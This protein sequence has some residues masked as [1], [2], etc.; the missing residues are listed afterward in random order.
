MNFKTEEDVLKYAKDKDITT[1][2]LKFPDL[3]GRIHHVTIPAVQLQDTLEHGIP[4]DG[5]SVPGFKSVES[6]DMALFPD[7]GT[8][9]IDPFWEENTISFLCKILEPGS[10]EPFS[11]DPRYIVRKA[12]SYMK[13]AGIADLSLWGPEFEFYIFDSVLYQNDINSSGYIID[14]EEAAWNTYKEGPDN[15]GNKIPHGGGYH[16][17]PP[18][19]HFYNLRTEMASIMAASGIDIRYHH[20]EAGGPG[21][22][23]IEVLL[24]PL[25]KMADDAMW[26]KYIIK[27]TARKNN[28]TVTFMPKPL[29][30][31]AGSGMH[32]HQM[33]FKDGKPLFY[34][35]G[36][37][38]DLSKLALYYIGGILKH[39]RALLALTNPSTNSYKRLIPGFEAPVNLFFSLANRSAAIRIPKDAITPEKKR[40]EF[41]PSDAT[42]NMYLAM[43]AQLMAGLDGI[44]NKIDPVEEGYG[45]YDEN[46]FNWNEQQRSK[47]QYLPFSLLEALEC[48]KKDH[49][50]LL[51]GDVF[52]TD[53][54][55]KWIDYKTYQE[56]YNVRNR[57]HPMEI[58]LYYDV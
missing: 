8:A 5:S 3:I 35:K 44:I 32:F 15:L 27:M 9:K 54:I 13:S 4:F 10:D 1:V 56:Y 45:P 12:L 36:N 28:K 21:Q 51:K 18:L 33:L 34:E 17:A 41:R 42:C 38:A 26:I 29:Y 47:L 37:Y 52:T 16:A 31:E 22:S 24:S 55:E 53:L 6:G 57:P 20:H 40:I 19:D 30:D 7:I 49:E 11:R 2:D 25:E 46:V 58:K 43:T 23:E 48:L 39:G 50:F 14:S